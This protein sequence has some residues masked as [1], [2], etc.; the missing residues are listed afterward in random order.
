VGKK[1]PALPGLERPKIPELSILGAAYRRIVKKRVKLTAEETAAREALIAAMQKH[2]QDAY[3][4]DEHVPP[5]E[6]ILTEGKVK[7][8]VS[9]LSPNATTE[10]AEE[11]DDDEAEEA[12][13]KH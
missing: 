12:K 7:V 1:Q 3:V 13:E 2:K 9:E 5:L 6:I 10:E 8:K 4:D 11:E